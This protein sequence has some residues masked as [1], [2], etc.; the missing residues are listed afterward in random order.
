MAVLAVAGCQSTGGGGGGG[1]SDQQLVQNLINDMMAALGAQDIEKMASFYGE[2]FM[3][4]SGGPDETREFLEG[5][6]DQG[7]L[8][9]MEVDISGLEIVIDGDT[10]TAEPVELDGAFGVVTLAFELAKQ[11]GQ[12]KVV[13][14]EQY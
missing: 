10:A 5:A 11:N 7:F 1:A 9:D 6:K 2:G 14:Q 8:D 3:S 12:W 4:D 13:S